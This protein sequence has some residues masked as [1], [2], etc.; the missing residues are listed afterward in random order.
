M[1][2]GRATSYGRIHF[3]LVKLPCLHDAAI[4]AGMGLGYR[5]LACRLMDHQVGGQLI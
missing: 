2:S 3:S 4:H 5:T 1:A